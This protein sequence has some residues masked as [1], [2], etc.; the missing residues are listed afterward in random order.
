MTIHR[1]KS[2]PSLGD[3]ELP[4]DGYIRVSR[5]GDRSG[6]SYISPDVQRS[7]LESW[8]LERGVRLVVHDP[9]ENVSGATMDRPVFNRIMR[10]IRA[11]ESGGIVVYKL[12]RFA[13]T[14]V[15]GLTT[16][17]ELTDHRA[18]FASATEPLF[19]FTTADG[20][21]FLQINLMM[22]E[23]FR[24]RT[25]ESW[26]SS[27]THAVGRGVHIAPDV[28]YGYLKDSSKRLVPDTRA[29]FV[30]QAFERRA[31]GWPFQRIADWLN[32]EA[33]PR[34]DYR[35]WTASSVERMVRRRVYRG[36]AHWGEHEN[37][38]AH[39]ALVAD[40][41]WH[42]AQRQVQR[43]SKRRQAAGIALL[44]GIVRCAGCRF[45]MSRALH[46]TGN[47]RYRRQYYRCRV[48]RVSGTCAT[49]A[50]LRGDGPDGLESYVEDI[51][52]GELDRRARTFVGISDSQALAEALAGLE[53]AREDLESMRRDTAARR[54]LGPLWLSFVEPL[55]EAVELAERRVAELQASR[56]SPGLSGLTADAYRSLERPERAA[57]LRAMIDCVFCRNFGH[58][59]GPQALPIDERRVRILWRGQGPLDLPAHNKASAVV[60]WTGFED[61][62]PTG[63]SSG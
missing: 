51:V 30:V 22:A 50:M 4:V 48:F 25:R 20:R 43:Y 59:R 58:R 31:Q 61:E 40:E 19:D 9:E 17:N 60:P 2:L 34:A 23:Y 5:V 56:G 12:D 16:L 41:V 33:P 55:V 57:V 6:E 32:E 24:E 21:I 10:R 46:R 52:C 14:L 1:A 26:E 49:P 39:P 54:R 27:L 3:L 29:P 44:H 53:A 37:R 13:R 63:M 36:V 38:E 11:R 47:H 42:R 35:A 18:L 15:G 7:A 62:P 45:L 28:P 8:A